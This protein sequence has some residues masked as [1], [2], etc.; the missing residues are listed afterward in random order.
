MSAMFASLPSIPMELREHF[1]QFTTPVRSVAQR[2]MDNG[3]LSQVINTPKSPEQSSTTEGASQN[4]FSADQESTVQLT[5]PEP[6]SVEVST[7][8]SRSEKTKGKAPSTAGK[9]KDKALTS[10]RTND[11][12][13]TTEK[14]LSEGKSHQGRSATEHAKKTRN[15]EGKQM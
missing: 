13:S 11:R 12:A 4:G 6:S 1:N 10:K 9:T 8:K 2:T 7:A 5:S 14:S 15:E 3:E